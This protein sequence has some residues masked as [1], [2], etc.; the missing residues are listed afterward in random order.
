VCD[1]CRP[2]HADGIPT[3]QFLGCSHKGRS[4]HVCSRSCATFPCSPLP[5]TQLSNE[6][7]PVNRLMQWEMQE[8]AARGDYSE[9][10]PTSNEAPCGARWLREKPKSAPFYTEADSSKVALCV[11]RC[12]RSCC[13]LRPHI[14]EIY[15]QPPSELRVSHKVLAQETNLLYK[16]KTFK[17]LAERAEEEG[18]LRPGEQSTR[19][20]ANPLHP[21]CACIF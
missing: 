1:A 21:D 6:G 10:P 3:H 8:A 7:G 4:V 11:W 2:A 18:L 19:L 12:T 15:F 9:S 16:G 13:F 14:D 5:K 20:A 17:L